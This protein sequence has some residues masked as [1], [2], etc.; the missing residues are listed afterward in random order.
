MKVVKMTLKP[1]SKEIFL[2]MIK[3][4]IISTGKQQGYK[5]TRKQKS[6]AKDRIVEEPLIEK[7]EKMKKK[8]K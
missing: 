5:V 2:E 4:G 3:M 8:Q 6:K 7:Y 1:V